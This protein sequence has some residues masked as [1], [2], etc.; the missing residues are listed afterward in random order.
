MERSIRV[1]KSVKYDGTVIYRDEF[2]Y[3]YLEMNDEDGLRMK[4][5][6]EEF[7]IKEIAKVESLDTFTLLVEPY[8]K[9]A[10]VKRFYNALNEIPGMIERQTEGYKFVK[11]EEEIYQ[12]IARC[13]PGDEE[14]MKLYIFSLPLADMMIHDVLNSEQ[15]LSCINEL[16][17]NLL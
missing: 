8:Y 11:E 3:E 13:I 6:R 16:N 2:G 14:K 1:K 5:Y 9:N 10:S 12:T 17:M 7:I 4:S 15:A